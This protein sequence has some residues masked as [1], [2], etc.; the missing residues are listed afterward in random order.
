M[1]W[2]PLIYK[3]CD[4]SER[5]LVSDAGQIYSLKTNKILRQTLNKQT[6]YYGV[7][8][9]L[10]SRKKRKLIKT[11]I[12]VAVMFVDGYAE[13]LVV[14]HKDGDKKNNNAE[15][16]EW[17]TTSE[18]Q[19]HALNNGLR[20]DNQRIMCLNTGQIFNSVTDACRWCGLSEWSRSIKEYLNGQKNRKSAGKHPVTKEPLRWKLV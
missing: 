16:L 6:G 3:D 14:N 18:N 20:T 15:N 13:N 4:L 12:A 17:V 11:H 10:G 19:I 8:I 7:C 2:K 1:E 5:Y 9:S